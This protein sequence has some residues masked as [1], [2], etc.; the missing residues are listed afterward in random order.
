MTTPMVEIAKGE[1]INPSFVMRLHFNSLTKS[2][3]VT[4]S[5]GSTT[6]SDFDGPTTAKMLSLELFKQK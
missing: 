5:D 2:I 3:L 1:F 4:M 6:E